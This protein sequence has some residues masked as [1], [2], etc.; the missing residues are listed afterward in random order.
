MPAP[1]DEDVGWLDVAVNDAFGVRGIEGV[2]D[3][4]REREQVYG[5][6]VA[7]RSRA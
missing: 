5:K 3:L 7:G 4:D 1:S 6:G 2:G